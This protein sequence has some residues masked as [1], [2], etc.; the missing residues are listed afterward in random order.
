MLAS[1]V[2]G[3]AMVPDFLSEAL[4]VEDL[5]LAEARRTLNSDGAP[6]APVALPMSAPMLAYF[7]APVDAAPTLQQQRINETTSALFAT[8]RE[9]YGCQQHLPSMQAAAASELL[10]SKYTIS[11]FLHPVWPALHHYLY[12]ECDNHQPCVEVRALL[13]HLAH[14]CW[15][16]WSKELA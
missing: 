8:L 10:T 9:H 3:Q 12:Y 1:N 7:S 11:Q 15:T 5:T 4:S 6:P 13:A 14:K 2:S 16:L